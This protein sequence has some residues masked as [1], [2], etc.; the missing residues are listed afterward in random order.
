MGGSALNFSDWSTYKSKTIVGKSTA[1]IYTNRNMKDKYDPTKITVRESRD[2]DIMPVTTPII[3]GLD[4]TG[5][6][7][8]VL[9]QVANKLGEIVIGVMTDKVAPG[10][11]VMFAAMGDMYCDDAPL[12]VTQFE[13]DIRI[14]E[15]LTDL[16]FE[17][18]GGGNSSESYTA[19]WLFAARKTSI[20]SLEVRGQKGILI[21]IGDDGCP[22]GISKEEAERFLGITLETDLTTEQIYEEASQSYEIYHIDLSRGGWGREYGTYWKEILGERFIQINRNDI[23]KLDALIRGIVEVNAGVAV[24]DVVSKWSGDT[25]IVLKSALGGLSTVSE[26]DSGLIE[27]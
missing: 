9:S 3:I 1:A 8:D 21:T 17:Q 7:Q 12:Q 10:P 16:W 19:P 6:M 20:D 2:S 4:V 26:T 14:A 22:K 15:Q 27:L 18:G 11:Q 5:S 24:D 25:S 13:T 23:D